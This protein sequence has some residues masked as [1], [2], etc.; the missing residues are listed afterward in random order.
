MEINGHPESKTREREYNNIFTWKKFNGKQYCTEYSVGYGLPFEFRTIY[1]ASLSSD[2][3]KY[4]A[5]D[6]EEPWGYNDC[7]LAYDLYGHDLDNPE[8]LFS[9]F[10]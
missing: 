6:I 9:I 2:C 5:K 8:I 4:K 7:S 3:T 1:I 10:E